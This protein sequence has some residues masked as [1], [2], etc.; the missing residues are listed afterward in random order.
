[1][2]RMNDE[3]G[4]LIKVL[5]KRIINLR[6]II[7]KKKDEYVCS[8]NLFSPCLSREIKI[9][10]QCPS[11][12]TVRTVA[13]DNVIRFKYFLTFGSFASYPGFLFILSN[14]NCLVSP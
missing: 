3:V 9:S 10:K 5:P 8:H 2:F 11:D 6:L 1:M 7:S 4:I 13:S 14:T 12:F